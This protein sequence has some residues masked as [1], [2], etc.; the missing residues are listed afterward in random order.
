[1]KAD[2]TNIGSIKQQIEAEVMRLDPSLD[3]D[4]ESFKA[5]VVMLTAL[6]VGAVQIRIKK[7]LGYC[8]PMKLI[9]WFGYNLRKAGIWKKE[10][11]HSDWFGKDGG[12]T[13]WLDVCVA[14]GLME[15]K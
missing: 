5:A 3:K 13:F 6:K 9:S 14:Q 12:L 2:E 7:E 4:S 10:K 1:M 8:Y 11:T 15:R